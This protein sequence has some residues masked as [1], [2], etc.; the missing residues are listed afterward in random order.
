MN[1]KI[2]YLF[3]LLIALSPL[4]N[5][6]ERIREHVS[7][8]GP[9]IL[10]EQASNPTNLANRGILYSKDDSGDTELYF[11]DDGGTV[12]QITRD[13][14]VVVG[15]VD[16]GLNFLANA[17]MQLVGSSSSAFTIQNAADTTGISIQPRITTTTAVPALNFLNNPS[18]SS[19]SASSGTQTFAS[20]STAVN[21]TSTAAYSLIKGVATETALGSGTS[22][23]L[24]LLAGAAGSTEKFSIANTGKLASTNTAI[25]DSS[26]A[27]AFTGTLPASTS[28]RTDAFRVSVTSAGS[29]A[30]VQSGAYFT[31]GGG[32]TGASYAIAMQADNTAAGT[33]TSYLTGAANIGGLFNSS[34]TTTGSNVGF[35]GNASGG[36]FNAAI[37]G[38]ATTLKNSATNIGA[39]AIALNTGTSPVQVGGFFGLMNAAPTL[40]SSAGLI[41]DNGSTTS[42]IFVARDNGTAI[43]TIADGG[44]VTLSGRLLAKQGADVSSANDLTLGSDGS[45]FEIT[46]TTQINA[47]TTTGFQIGTEVTLLF[48]STPT[49]KHNTAGGAS[50]AVILLTGSSD[51]V[52]TAGSR[53]KLFYSELGG[54][55]AWREISRS[56][57]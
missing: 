10:A 16:T 24:Q 22:Y 49:I 52:A 1:K 43:F 54:T 46:G 38:A 3:W 17:T 32:Y 44:S 13:G 39:I 25:V 9:V 34:A 18:G 48:T 4:S 26:N 5:A 36:N 55:N 50:T 51:M 21:Q 31:L 28:G 33:G 41:A 2:Q 57:P 56:F 47:I 53:I 37:A 35:R 30:N 42:D 14:S 6:Q 40:A 12:T 11:I 23:L 45:L 19:F 8:T 20:F 15:T 7:P 29:S 27:W